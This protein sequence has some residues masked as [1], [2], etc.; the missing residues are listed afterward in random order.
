MVR[1]ATR[2]AGTVDF[3]PSRGQEAAV[4]AHPVHSWQA[5]VVRPGKACRNGWCLDVV[6]AFAVAEETLADQQ[7]EV[8]LFYRHQERN[9]LP[10][11][12]QQLEI[13]GQM[14]AEVLP[15]SQA[16]CR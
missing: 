11:H 6:A 12:S 8:R 3:G 9:Y 1:V 14:K 16:Y 7:G 5:D 10:G 4:A 15:L 2:A 13:S